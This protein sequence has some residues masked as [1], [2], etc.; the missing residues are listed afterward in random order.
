MA[1]GVSVAS[2]MTWEVLEL[3]LVIG[4]WSQV[5]ALLTVGSQV[6]R[7]PAGG[8]GWA[9][10]SRLHWLEGACVALLL[11]EARI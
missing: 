7:W 11:V 5:T 4:K 9:Q 2:C 8:W 10:G 3:V 1:L 6:W